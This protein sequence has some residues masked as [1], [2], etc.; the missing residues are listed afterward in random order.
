MASCVTLAP[1]RH[2]KSCL[3]AILASTIAYMTRALRR[4]ANSSTKLV[5]LQSLDA[6]IGSAPSCPTAHQEKRAS[7]S[8]CRRLAP[9]SGSRRR[10][11]PGSRGTPASGRA[12]KSSGALERRPARAPPIRRRRGPKT[13]LR[14]SGWPA[15]RRYAGAATPK[16]R[17]RP[18][19]TSGPR[20]SAASCRPARGRGPRTRPSRRRGN[21][22]SRTDLEPSRPGRRRRRDR[23]R[24]R[25]HPIGERPWT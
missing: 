14:S 10:I 13:V 11:L 23:R 8:D 6:I 7:I 18:W 17:R 12:E 24:P 3:V 9:S 19:A 2:C 1:L 20:R 4:I 25:R 5:P 15:R 16:A 21:A 22:P